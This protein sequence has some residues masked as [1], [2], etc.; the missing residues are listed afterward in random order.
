MLVIVLVFIPV[1]FLLVKYVNS[2]GTV[3]ETSA[4]E[5]VVDLK[6]APDFTLRDVEGTYYTLSDY[7]GKV[8]LL[9]F[10]ATWCPPCR[11]EI[12]HFIE[13]QDEYEEEGLEIL[14]VSMD[15]KADNILEP[16]SKREGINY[17]LL[18]GDSKVTALYGG[19]RSIP[20]TFLIDRKGMIRKK[21]IGYRDKEVF[22]K[23]IK[24]L[25]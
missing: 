10:W 21:Y 1:V 13:L 18:V 17:T 14:G 4:E 20:T 19:I 6:R 25:L 3:T 2:A 5:E 12:P 7:K 16:F 9:D 8:V 15:V 11:Q 22:E 23:D 24:E